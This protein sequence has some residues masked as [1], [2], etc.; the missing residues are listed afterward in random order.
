MDEQNI[1][2]KKSKRAI[3]NKKKKNKIKKVFIS[4]LLIVIILAGL[5]LG[6]GV[7]LLNGGAGADFISQM[8]GGTIHREPIYVLVLGVNP[9]LSDTIMLAGYDPTSRKSFCT[10]YS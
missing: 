10:F 7:I 8:F 2:K 6:A 1:Q 5:V 4:L 9:P 3:E